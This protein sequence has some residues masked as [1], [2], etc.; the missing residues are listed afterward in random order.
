MAEPQ[1]SKP[2]LKIYHK[3]YKKD[4]SS[5][6]TA[7]SKLDAD[8]VLDDQYAI[9]VL[10]V[11]TK[12]S[13][14]RRTAL[15][16][17]SPHILNA[18]REVVVSHPTVAEDFSEPFDLHSPFQMLFH[19]WDDLLAF[20]QNSKDDDERMHLGVLI[21]FMETELGRERSTL[22][23]SIASGSISFNRLWAIFPPRDVAVT[24]AKGE[25]WMLRVVATAY[26]ESMRIGEYMEVHCTFTDSDGTNV[27]E[28][29]KIVIVIQ[30]RNFAQDN[31]SPIL[32]LPIIPRS[33]LKEGDSLEARLLERGRRNLALQ[34][35]NIMQCN[36]PAEYLKETPPS[37]WH[38]EMGEFL[39]VWLPYTENGRVVLDRASFRHYTGKEPLEPKQNLED[40]D[41]MSFPPFVHGYSVVRM[42]WCRLWLST[43]QEVDWRPNAFDDLILPDRQRHLVDA[44]VSSHDFPESTS[45]QTKQ[46]GKGLVVLLYGPPGSGKTLTAECA[47]EAA[48]KPLFSTSLY[49]LNKYNDLS[50]FEAELGHLLRLATI[51]QAVV[52]F[53]EADVFLEHR[54]EEAASDA[55]AARNA[56]V[57]IFLRYMEYFSGIVFLTTNRIRVFDWAMKS[58]VHLALEYFAPGPESR[59]SIWS[60]CFTKI[61]TQEIDKDLSLDHALLEL[62]Q[63]RL[64]GREISNSFNTARTLARFE[65][66]P[67]TM[68]HL[69]SVLGA[70]HDFE[71]SLRREKKNSSM[72]ASS[73]Q[74][75]LGHRGLRRGS[76]LSEEPESI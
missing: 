50:S 62:S 12:E 23:K 31:P 56:L 69:Q 4:G 53:D 26:E 67:L 51:W 15:T 39:E 32:E 9:V 16:V 46:K 33:F 30:K 63:L 45:E 27:G 49:R 3:R 70:W 73:V 52:L 25:P 8:P 60:Q 18:F 11:F 2:E 34:G 35:K 28:V 74:N 42:D 10:R 59:K 19:S 72:S 75:V 1:G 64:N 58:R 40:F 47:A 55:G 71:Q 6:T 38:P 21:D 41:L 20:R 66:T 37:Y 17:N 36:G 65:K 76:I 54:S 5:E 7:V 24:Y 44:L 68:E 22:L 61:P 48:K 13:N 43:L 14:L 57:A 29:E